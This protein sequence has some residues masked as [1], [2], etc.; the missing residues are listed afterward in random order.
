[1]RLA[2]R[3]AP[4]EIKTAVNEAAASRGHRIRWNGPVERRKKIRVGE[5]E[6][7]GSEVTFRSSVENWNEYLLDD[8]TVLKVKMV[9][10]DITRLDQWDTEGNPLY[11]LRSTNVVST[12]P[13]EHLK[14]PR[15]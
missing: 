8:G 2:N 14:K 11:V 7:E 5:Q 9:L 15:T 10:T 1:V 13:P 12:S 4:T 6:V 3:T